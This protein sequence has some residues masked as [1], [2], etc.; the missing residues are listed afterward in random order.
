MIGR[1]VQSMF[2][3]FNCSCAMSRES[4]NVFAI[5]AAVIRRSGKAFAL[6]AVLA[7]AEL[8]A[9][10]PSKSNVPDTPE[11]LIFERD[12]PYREGHPR[13]VL[14]V[15]AP[16][17]TTSEP[18]AAVVLV[19]GGG[20]SAGDQYKFSRMGFM[21][22]NQGYVVI[23]PT[24]RLM[25]DAP[26]PACL[27]DLKN[28][29]RWVRAHAEKYHI[30]PDKIGAYGNSAGGTQALTAA[31]TNGEEEFEGDGP[32]EEFS[33]D[34]QAVVCSGAVGDMLHPTHS[35]RAANAYLNL[36]RGRDRSVS[37]ANARNVMRAA[38]PSSYIDKNAPP[39]LLVHG[40]EDTVVIVDSTDEFADAM[41]AAGADLTYLRYDDAGHAVMGQKGKETTP[42]M[43]EFFKKHL[44][45]P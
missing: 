24:Y 34:L 11:G 32:Y 43:L 25:Q 42:A 39:I 27:Q 2:E 18:R 23:L 35:E 20:W 3:A 17:Q 19:H 8:L 1:T 5:T 38:S 14:N 28:G 44:G 12:I 10:E 15:I 21:L 6:L 4:V 29:I 26:F 30:N 22:A 13:W 36:A 9:Q 16:K 31:L 33:S 41:K 37:E 45:S 7:A 40:V